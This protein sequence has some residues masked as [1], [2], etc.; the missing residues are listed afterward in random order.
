[1]D[2]LLVK[3]MLGEATP[4]EQ[5]QVQAWLERETAN[6]TY[7]NQLHAVWEKSR[8]IEAQTTVSENDAWQRFQQ[9]VANGNQA[10]RVIP[11]ASNT[12]NWW[13][14]AAAVLVLGVGSWLVYTTVWHTGKTVITA[15]NS[16]VTDTLPDGS[17]VTLNRNATVSYERSF[18]GNSRA[19]TLE[20]EAFFNI[21]P[22]K[23][24]PFTITTGDDVVIK[25]LGTSFNVKTAATVTEVIVET[26]LVEVS[27]KQQSIRLQQQE[28]VVIT[29]SRMNLHKQANHSELYNHY[30]THSFVCRATPLSELVAVLNEAY[31]ADIVIGNSRLND[32]QLTT[33]FR[34]ASL[35]SIIS[36]VCQ[37]LNIKARR[38]N[39]RIILE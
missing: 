27:H 22:D 38:N 37:T 11:V 29:A 14:I 7:Y 9:R 3:Y 5:E 25:V 8:I 21:T 20:G 15:G 32:L 10:A 34:E 17:V 1:M 30:R 36:I 19:I 26:G 35:D 28:K 24:R 4:G 31:D 13:R 2:D 12:R 18:G 16:V 33:V 23:S 39:N 6:Q